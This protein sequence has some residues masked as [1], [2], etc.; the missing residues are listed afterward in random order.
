MSLL[1]I[2]GCENR[3]RSWNKEGRIQQ[4]KVDNNGYNNIIAKKHLLDLF[5][6]IGSSSTMVLHQLFLGS[7]MFEVIGFLSGSNVFFLYLR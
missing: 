5:I 2:L 4:Q 1:F 6:S 7:F 3:F